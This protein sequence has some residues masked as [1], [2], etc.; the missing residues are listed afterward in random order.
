MKPDF[1]GADHFFWRAISSS[2]I[3]NENLT[4]T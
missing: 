4:A 1:E 2:A 3:D